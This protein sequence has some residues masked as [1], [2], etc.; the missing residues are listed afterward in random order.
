MRMLVWE[1]KPPQEARPVM[2]SVEHPAPPTYR[3]SPRESWMVLFSIVMFEDCGHHHSEPSLA[4]SEVGTIRTSGPSV[5]PEVWEISEFRTVQSSPQMAI[6]EPG[7]VL[8]TRNPSIVIL[9]C[10]V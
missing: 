6:A 3:S 2:S 4:A 7:V 5:A 1:G 9:L 8:V 10:L